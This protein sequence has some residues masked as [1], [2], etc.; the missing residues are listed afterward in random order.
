MDK[1]SDSPPRGVISGLGQVW[2][3]MSGTEGEKAYGG[4]G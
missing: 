4:Y 2:R 3:N 1:T